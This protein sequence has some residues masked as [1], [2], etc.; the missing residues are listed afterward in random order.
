MDA[1]TFDQTVGVSLDHEGSLLYVESIS[2][3]A[4]NEQWPVD[5]NDFS[6]F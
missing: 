3:T 2:N 4:V 5:E 1:N 6:T